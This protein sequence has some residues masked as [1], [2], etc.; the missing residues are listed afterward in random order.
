MGFN[1]PEGS[2]VGLSTAAALTKKCREVTPHGLLGHFFG[3]DILL[4]LLAQEG[5]MG[6]RPCHGLG[7]GGVQQLVAVGAGAEEND[8]LGTGCLVADEA[9]P[10]PPSLG[11]P[12][13]LNS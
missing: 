8:Q 11:S 10:C 13:V 7:G 3:R 6:I 4:N 9:M 5:C 1:G 12:N 2:P